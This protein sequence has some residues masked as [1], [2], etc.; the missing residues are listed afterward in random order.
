MQENILVVGVFDLLHRGHVELLRAARALGDRLFVIVNGDEL[1]SRYKRRPIY[2]EVDR[3][4]IVSALASVDVA[5]VSNDNDIKPYIEKFKITKVVHG[6][7]WPHEKYLTQICCSEQYLAEKGVEIVY[8]PYWPG[9][10][11][12]ATIRAMRQEECVSS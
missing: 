2:S 4:A 12:S 5:V 8:T 7:D 10:S 3:H 9:V 6:D 11:T 1:T